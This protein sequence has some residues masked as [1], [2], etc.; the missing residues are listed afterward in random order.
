[1]IVKNANAVNGQAGAELTISAKT[2]DT[3]RWRA[4]SLSL[5]SENEVILCKYFGDP[6]LISDP[7]PMLAEVDCPLPN[8]D[9]PYNPTTQTINTY[10]FNSVVEKVGSGRVT[11]HFVFLIIDRDGNKIGYYH[12]DPFINISR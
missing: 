6:K 3:I 11:Y 9:D 12:W 1:M 8:P 7:E 10:F 4:T 2:L 5:N